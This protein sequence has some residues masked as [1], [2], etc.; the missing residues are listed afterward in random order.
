MAPLLERLTKGILLLDGAMGTMLQMHGFAKQ[1]PE[2]LNLHHPQAIAGI[3]RAYSDAGSDLILT[4]TFGASRVKLGKHGL[5]DR[6]AEINKAAVSIARKACPESVIV[7][8]LGPLGGSIEPLGSLTFSQAL[9]AYKEQAGL[10]SGCDVLMF[11]TISDIQE[12]RAGLIAARSAFPGPIISSM[13][14]QDGRTS[15]GTDVET[16][17]RVAEALGADVIGANCSDGPKGMLATL[18]QMASCTDK[19]ICVE[20]NAGMPRVDGSQVTWDC[21]AEE[22][23][24]YAKRFADE[25]AA[26]IGGCCGTTPAYIHEIADA[27]KGMRPRLRKLPAK[28]VLCSRTRTLVVEPTLLA[29]ERINPT[30]RK[31]FIAELKAGSMD[32]VRNQA[33]QQREEGA[34]L[35]DINVGVPGTDEAALLAKAVA[36]VQNIVDLP[37]VIDSA[38]PKAI[39]A[40]LQ[41]YAGKALV[42]SVNGTDRSLAEILPLAKRYGASCIVLCLDDSGIPQTAEGRLAIAKRV[43]ERAAKLGIPTADLLFDAVTLTLATD[44]G[45]E[46]LTLETLQG[47][48]RLG[49]RTVLGISNVSHGLPNRSAINHQF[50]SKAKRLGLDLAIINPLDTI[51]QSD[52]TLHVLMRAKPDYHDLPVEEQLFLAVLY[53][54]KDS[55]IPL[56]EKALERLSALAINDIL[57]MALHKVGEKF[58]A[59]EYFLPQVLQSAEAMKVAFSR[60]KAELSKA[61][62]REAGCVLFATVENDIHD[63]G[64]NIVIALLESHHYRVIDLGVNVKAS[65]IIKEAAAHKPDLV[66]LSTLM[67]TTV[68]EMEQVVDG[69]RA[70]GI[71][72]PVIVG[73][74]VITD[75]FATQIK[76]AYAKDALAAVERINE[77]IKH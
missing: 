15:T 69:L 29:G 6:V 76:A 25:G 27:V 45:N 77:L 18:R 70:A 34:S 36:T 49:L 63:I 9:A 26:I 24:R 72:V 58:N 52:T 11:E 54:D 14:F 43:L 2:T 19:P 67:T 7:G 39:E 23:A 61:G 12:L 30:N 65:R 59:K 51:A 32:Y 47:L 8:D 53:G 31:G 40:A 17:V 13:T 55:I 73:G 20:P 74:A 56:I 21:S 41:G 38:S 71:R 60:L 22:F 3:H 10:L 66:A 75:D 33:M 57:I 62:G 42:N 64:K 35:L 1:V 46:Q 28:S 50:F 48:K 5:G 16:Y 44:I 68:A 37:L 4:N